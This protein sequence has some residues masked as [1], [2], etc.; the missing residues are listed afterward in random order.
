MF[1]IK[2]SDSYTWPVK[3]E[4]PVDGGGFK[5]ETFDGEF[6]RITQSR[7]KA[8]MESL[9]PDREICREILIG[10][11]GVIGEDGQEMP[12][13]ESA[14]DKLLDIPL[15]AGAVVTAFLD[16]YTGRAKVKNS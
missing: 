10:W 15:V 12:F 1:K 6:L 13:S 5:A 7:F 11:K 2:Q 8:M 9:T 14:R 4:V 3:F 16:A